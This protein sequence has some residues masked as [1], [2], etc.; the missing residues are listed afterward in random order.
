MKSIFANETERNNVINGLETERRNPRFYSNRSIMP[1]LEEDK[2]PVAKL[3]RTYNIQVS[4]QN[5]DDKVTNA[6]FQ[7]L[8]KTS[9]EAAEILRLYL[10]QEGN[11]I[12][13]SDYKIVKFES[14]QDGKILIPENR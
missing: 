12:F 10:E 1:I 2:P 6:T 11:D 4:V 13:G 5:A 9:R 3:K 14:K 8:S 7:I